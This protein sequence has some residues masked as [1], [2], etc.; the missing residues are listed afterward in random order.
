MPAD[1]PAK[2]TIERKG[3]PESPRR[4]LGIDDAGNRGW[5]A[6]HHPFQVFDSEAAA[7]DYRRFRCPENTA[8][9]VVRRNTIH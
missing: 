9:T 1:L 4:Y 8:D 5:M 3:N 2:W 7:K 6:P